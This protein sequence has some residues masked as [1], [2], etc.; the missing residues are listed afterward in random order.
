M[1]SIIDV[2]ITIPVWALV[3]V[4]L[5]HIPRPATFAW[6]AGRKISLGLSAFIWEGN[7]R[8]KTLEL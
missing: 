8:G 3:S 5:P 2:S 4:L 6:K 1:K 7:V